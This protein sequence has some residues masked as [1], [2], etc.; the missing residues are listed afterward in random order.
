M[1]PS[2]EID[3]TTVND[4]RKIPMT[5]LLALVVFIHIAGWAYTYFF[6]GPPSTHLMIYAILPVVMFILA[7][8]SV[9]CP[10]SPVIG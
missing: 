5:R 6:I 8:L 2:Y 4:D 10:I 9:K 1:P 3:D 7:L